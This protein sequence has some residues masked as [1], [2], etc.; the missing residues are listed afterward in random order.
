SIKQLVKSTKAYDDQVLGII[1]NN[2]GD[3]SS[4]GYV[5]SANDNPMPVALMGRLPVKVTLENGSIKAGDYLVASSTPGSAMKAVSAGVVIGQAI[6]SYD[7]NGEAT[8]VAF[9]KR[10]YY[11]P[12]TVIDADGNLSMQTIGSTEISANTNDTAYI[13]DQNGSGDLLQLQTNNVDRLLVQNNGAMNINVTP[14]SEDEEL[15][16]I[17][18]NDEEI[19]SIDAHG[20]VAFSGNITVKDDTFAGSIATDVNGEAQIMFTYDL[21]NGKPDVQLT[22]EG[23]TVAL[24]QIASFEKDTNGN[25]IGFNIKAV[26]L[27]G[28]P[29]SVIVHYLVIGKE[30][31]YQTSGAVIEVVEAPAPPTPPTEEVTPQPEEVITEEPATEEST[32]PQVED[33]TPVATTTDTTPTE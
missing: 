6:S 27:G 13:I 20:L 14:A 7:G 5:V 25:Y 26:G 22:V 2:Y 33:S 30:D 4:T 11:D 8:V 12:T 23:E 10:F 32:E 24:A 29:S 19:F 1:S 16:V 21:G 15:F 18:S 28:E 31:G 3:F 9:V 17:K